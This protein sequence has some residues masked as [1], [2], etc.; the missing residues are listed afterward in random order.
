MIQKGYTLVQ[1]G[2]AEEVR[3]AYAAAA[4]RNATPNR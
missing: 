3:A 1:K 2:Q 4:Q